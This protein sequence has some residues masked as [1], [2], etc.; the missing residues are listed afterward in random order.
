[1]NE[2]SYKFFMYKHLLYFEYKLINVIYIHLYSELLWVNLLIKRKNE[3]CLC[4]GN[5][6]NE[7]IFFYLDC[8]SLFFGEFSGSDYW[9]GLKPF[10]L[11]GKWRMWTCEW[12]SWI[13]NEVRKWR[14]KRIQQLINS[15]GLLCFSLWNFSIECLYGQSFHLAFIQVYRKQ[16]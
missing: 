14:G 13:F 10:F 6:R 4:F 3:S 2:R 15:W 5:E 7:E 8:T 12:D 16:K 11:L 9:N 1:M